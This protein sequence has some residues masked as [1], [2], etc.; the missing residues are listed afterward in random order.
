MAVP[1]KIDDA[2]FAYATPRQ[3]EVLEAVN[4]HGSAKAASV[5]LGINVGAA[6][7]AHIAVRKKAAEAGYAPESGINHPVAQGFQLKGYSHLTKT[8]SGENIWLKTEAVRE[9]WER[10][11]TDSIANCAMRQINIP[12][13]KVQTFDG[14]DIIPWLNIG[15]AHIGML[16][17]K[18]EVGQ[19][20]DLKIAK[21]ELLQAAFDLI[22]MAPDCERM[23]I[24]DLGDGTHYENM[25]AMTERSGHQVDFDSRFPKMVEAYL[26]IMEAIIEK[27]LTKA[28][29]VDVIINQGNHSE[30][31]D[32]WAAHYFRRLYGRLGS[33][34]V[35]VLKNESPFIGY[36]MGNTFVLV[37][38]GHKCKPEAL[39]QIMSTDYR[40]DWG[41]AKF[42]YIDGGH[43]HHFSAKELGGAQ[44][45]SFNN[46][47]PLDKYA[48]D[49]GWRSKQAMT[50]VLRSR[51]YG[52]I[53]RYKMPIEKVWN[54][55][56]KVNPTHYIPEPKR[57]F[58]A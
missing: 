35:N 23:V 46:L 22:D 3:R 18:D 43:I 8:V 27:A 9:R 39:R 15:D 10:A 51:T 11:V 17:H 44:W 25:K 13:P 54:A 19:N 52:D 30:T 53:G 24:N 31:N 7:D 57:A 40:I 49:G 12:P 20:F 14:A 33:N 58:L 5:A 1:L 28:V 45:E 32:Y 26:D 16:A 42:C 29:T 41:E 47:A 37:H 55:I 6:S 50:L 4:I 56:S 38:H 21:I 36:R 34:R 2:L 48:H